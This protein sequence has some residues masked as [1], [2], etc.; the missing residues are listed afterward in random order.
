MQE[1]LGTLHILSSILNLV[2]RSRDVN[3][4]NRIVSL[5]QHVE[6]NP[7]NRTYQKQISYSA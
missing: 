1:E 6:E 5:F 7:N 4:I 2:N 3:Q